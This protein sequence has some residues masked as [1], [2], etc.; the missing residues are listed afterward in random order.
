MVRL[1]TNSLTF[2]RYM[3]SLWTDTC[4]TTYTL[5]SRATEPS[6]PA[7]PRVIIEWSP[8]TKVLT[9]QLTARDTQEDRPGEAHISSSNIGA[10]LTLFRS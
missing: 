5:A 3:V 6:R 9:D 4:G 2:L 1:V 7:R 10:L 8:H